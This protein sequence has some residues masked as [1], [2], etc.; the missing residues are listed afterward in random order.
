MP[1]NLDDS[2]HFDCNWV[3]DNDSIWWF[4]SIVMLVL[5]CY[6]IHT[7]YKY[8]EQAIA[9]QWKRTFLLI[10]DAFICIVLF[11]LGIFFESSEFLNTV[12]MIICPPTLFLINI[13]LYLKNACTPKMFIALLF[14]DPLLH[15]MSIFIGLLIIWV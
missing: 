5:A 7:L 8:K 1:K 15:Y 10:A 9:I 12:F 11:C 6:A 3:D 4:F 14:T 13:K 2:S